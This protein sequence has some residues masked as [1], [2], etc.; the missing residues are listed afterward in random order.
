MRGE[1][2]GEDIGELINGGNKLDLEIF[3]QHPLTDEM[4]VHFNMFGSRM[5]DRVGGDSES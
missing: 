5:E 3:T 1:P 2:F 4:E